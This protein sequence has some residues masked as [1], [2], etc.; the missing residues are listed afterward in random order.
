MASGFLISVA[1]P[2]I[3][4]EVLAM[5]GGFPRTEW[6]PTSTT[7]NRGSRG[8][9]TDNCNKR[10][11][12]SRHE[13]HTWLTCLT[14]PR[15]WPWVG[16]FIYPAYPS[17]SK[18]LISSLHPKSTHRRRLHGTDSLVPVR[19]QQQVFWSATAPHHR[20]SSLDLD[21]DLYRSVL[22]SNQPPI[23]RPAPSRRTRG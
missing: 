19:F 16:M 2:S 4:A 12:W 10:G 13:Y 7:I 18:A 5:M 14:V 20:T 23:C 21:I 6:S 1:H 22:G 8:T 15:P 3:K 9:N 17:S 11:A